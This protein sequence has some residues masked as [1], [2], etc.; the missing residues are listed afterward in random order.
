MA[1]AA[2][3]FSL[4]AWLAAMAAVARLFHEHAPEPY[5]V[6]RI[7]LRTPQHGQLHASC[8]LR[9]SVGELS[10]ASDGRDKDALCDQGGF[11][12]Q[13]E[14]FHVPQ[15]QQYC[16][17]SF[18]EWDPK[19]TTFPGLYVAGTA[20]AH[21]LHRGSGLLAPLL[22]TAQLPLVSRWVSARLCISCATAAARRPA[23]Q[24]TSS[25]TGNRKREQGSVLIHWSQHRS[26]SPA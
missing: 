22:G 6:R 17:G 11:P 9:H 20:Y 15:T 26:S 5:M 8:V 4:V 19:I 18:Q 23:V 24:F 13:D 16:R 12:V 14:P 3:T 2:V 7:A 25:F 1:S 10:G 21:L